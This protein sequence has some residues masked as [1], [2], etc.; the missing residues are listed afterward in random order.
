M[1]MEIFSNLW[2]MCR[3]FK[4]ASTLNFVGLTVAFASFYIFM[5]Q[6]DYG[7]SY[8]RGIDD[9]ERVYRLEQT[10]ISS[11]F[12]NYDIFCSRPHIEGLAQI[13][14]IEAVSGFMLYPFDWECQKNG[15]DMT[16][17]FV[18]G[19]QKPLSAFS[20]KCL[21]GKLEWTD[22][23]REGVLI[24]ASM[25]MTYFGEVQVAGRYMYGGGD[26]TLIR[27]VFEDFPDNSSARNIMYTYW[28]DADFDVPNNLNYGCFIKLR[29]DVDLAEVEE[30][31]R[32]SEY[33]VYRNL[34][35][36]YAPS[37]SEEDE[38]YFEE[39]MSK[40]K[41]RLTPIDE[42][43]FSGLDS[44]FDKG[45]KGMM[46]VL[47][48]ACLLV[49]VVA[50]INFLN[51]TL[52]E[53]PMRIKSVNTR[54]VLG[55]DL[56]TQRMELIGETTVIS[57]LACVVGMVIAYLLAEMPKMQELVAGSVAISDNLQILAW[58]FVVSLL[59]GIASGVYPSVYVTS[60]APALV[61]K[62]SFG[63]SPKGKRLRTMLV[64]FQLAVSFFMVCYIGVLYL[65]SHYIFNSD[66]GFDKD[67]LYYTVLDNERVERFDEIEQ[68]L[69]GIPGVEAIS[70]SENIIGTRDI[71]SQWGRHDDEHSVLF[72]AFV[73]DWRFLRTMGIKVVE[74]RNFSEH[75]GDV[76]IINEAARKQWDWVEMDKLLLKDDMPVVGVCENVRFGSMRQ[77]NASKPLAFVVPGEELKE[78]GWDGGSVVNIRVAA[79][80]DRAVVRK[81]LEDC[82][83]EVEGHGEIGVSFLDQQLEQTYKEE[84]RFISQVVIFSIVC[85]LITL[86]GVFCLT[87]FETEY[88]RKEIGLRKIMGSTVG[89]VLT[90]LCR[91][92]AV[93]IVASFV[94]SAPVAWYFGSEW[95]KNFA[96]RTE[97]H[98]W[99]FPASFVIVGGVTLLTVVVQS[100][101][102]A[103]DN[104]IN[105][106]KTE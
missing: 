102:V 90:M 29:E 25:A 63:L 8:N 101:K 92:Y 58:T 104:P 20:P 68:K 35:A 47:E 39:F 42:T 40:R 1:Y 62:G 21:D 105:S 33:K 5:T 74:G 2:Y 60:F 44:N 84:F 59:L 55:K 89:G 98:W 72:N 94:L 48:L 36:K 83:N 26:S 13:P 31:V 14:Q 4:L 79:G 32:E 53:S 99:L 67:Q 16:F 56:W 3:R 96:E 51:F 77:D 12:Q 10:S 37:V 91:R 23:D 75:D 6:V 82:V 50:G 18:R 93:L 45:N 73:V 46:L 38:G 95:L 43:Y 80:T 54:R 24:P 76:Y 71:Y 41:A 7:R 57:L 81:Q 9:Y 88:R 65:Q 70:R 27:G 97:I 17:Q 106:I 30:L 87:M 86:I 49:I 85:L 61:L 19:C 66:Y 28:K 11:D 78:K 103:N 15:S 100:W 52:A 69:R 22:E 34:A 64:A